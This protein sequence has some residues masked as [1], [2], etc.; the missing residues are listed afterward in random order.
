M[1]FVFQNSVDRWFS[2]MPT[3]TLYSKRLSGRMLAYNI[4]V[5]QPPGD[6]VPK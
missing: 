2:G 4:A 6:V 5:M 3:V 1:S